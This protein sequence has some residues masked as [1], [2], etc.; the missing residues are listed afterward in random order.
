MARLQ[1]EFCTK[2]FFRATKFLTKNAPKYSPKFLSLCS[3]IKKITERRGPLRGHRVHFSEVSQKSSQ[4]LGERG[5]A[6]R[7]RGQKMSRQSPTFFRQFPAL[8]RHSNALFM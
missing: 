7:G 8:L 5:Q 1:S 2:D 4:S 6:G 3:V